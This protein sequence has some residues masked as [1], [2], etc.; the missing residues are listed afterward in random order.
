MSDT[1]FWHPFATMGSIRS[2]ECVIERGEDVWVWDDRGRRLLDAT[3]SLWYANVGHGRKAIADAVAAQMASIET[4][5]CFGDFANRPALELCERLARLAPVKDAR[6]FLGSG[7]GDGIDTAA[8]LARR[9]FAETGHPERERIITRT[10]AYHGTHGFGTSLAGIPANRAGYGHLIEPIGIVDKDS[11]DALREE[12]ERVGA[13]RVAAFFAEPVIGAGG[14]HPPRPGYLEACAEICR[15]A[16]VLF[17]ADC[18]IVGFGRL[19]GWTGVERFGLEPD[20]IV[21]AKGVTSGYLP[22]GGV[23]VSG[24]IAAPFWDADSA[25]A[26]RHGATYAG[27]AACAAAALANLDILESE[28]LVPRGQELEGPLLEALRP[29]ARHPLVS[30]VRGGVGLLAAVELDASLLERDPGAPSSMAL[31]ARD[32]AGVLLRALASGLA[33]S[34]PLTIQPEHIEQIADGCRAALDHTLATV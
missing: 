7:G 1:R 29:L 30:E 16:G 34:P 14:V 8:K 9:Y 13:D 20:M 23:I 27:H 3:A 2:A 22:L 32:E 25:P 6:V 11:P 28:G 31:H 17:V 10:S 12:I 15:D 33:V 24:E 4:Y 5:S 21:F 18:V 19:G 26:L